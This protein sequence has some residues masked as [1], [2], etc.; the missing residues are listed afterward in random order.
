MNW[1][2]GS[3]DEDR[4]EEEEEEE[5]D[6]DDDDDDDEEEEEEEE[7]ESSV[8]DAASLRLDSDEEGKS[9]DCLYP[10]ET[11]VPHYQECHKVH[12]QDQP[13]EH[14]E[15][16]TEGASSGTSGT[17]ASEESSGEPQLTRSVDHS[18][19]SSH[20]VSRDPSGIT[21]PLPSSCHTTHDETLLYSNS[22]V[23]PQ[24]NASTL[25]TELCTASTSESQS[26]TPSLLSSE[27]DG[28][29][30]VV[31]G[32]GGIQ[33]TKS[34]EDKSCTA[35]T[36]VQP[37]MSSED[38]S[39]TTS[40]SESQSNT[41]PLLCNDIISVVPEESSPTDR[42]EDKSHSART[43][44]S[45]SNTPPLLSSEVGGASYVDP[46]DGSI[47]PTSSEDESCTTETKK[48]QVWSL[49]PHPLFS[50]EQNLVMSSPSR[51]GET[52][53]ETV[54]GGHVQLPPHPLK[55]QDKCPP[56]VDQGEFLVLDYHA[57]L[58]FWEEDLR[59]RLVLNSISGEFSLVHRLKPIR[60]FAVALFDVVISCLFYIEDSLDE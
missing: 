10:N 50:T 9:G 27:V 32:D 30:H 4:E 21:D 56:F 35:S 2:Q 24:S 43:G 33:P 47:Q 52:A 15:P 34:S 7:S 13:G 18:S 37:T 1:I 59:T 44:K 31:S 25:L 28:V 5:E 46:K 42:S 60:I 6:D 20:V 51:D 11:A 16:T 19:S 3:A 57:V 45:R 38:E 26:N 48:S 29:S 22:L 12:I 54:L 40:T 58:F 23:Q 8:S 14:R 53:R 17:E 39:R 36:G 49:P 41:P 55:C